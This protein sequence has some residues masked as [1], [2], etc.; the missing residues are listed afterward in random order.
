MV[1][2][3]EAAQAS[4]ISRWVMAMSLTAAT[5]VAQA[6]KDRHFRVFQD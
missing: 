5:V 6:V 4:T 1:K 3:K 2:A